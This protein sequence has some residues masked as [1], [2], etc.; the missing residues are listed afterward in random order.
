LTSVGFFVSYWALKNPDNSKLMNWKPLIMSRASTLLASCLLAGG[1]IS[2][3]AVNW[4]GGSLDS[5][6]WSDT[7]NWDSLLAPGS[8]DVVT[9]TSAGSKQEAGV[10]DNVVDSD[11]TVAS[12][13][14][15]AP[16]SAITPATNYHTTLIN[17]G[18]TLTLD[19]GEVGAGLLS[20]GQT[21]DSANQDGQFYYTITGSGGSLIAGNLESPKTNQG[22]QVTATQR[23]FTNHVGSLDLSGLD[24]FSMAGGYFWVGI[25]GDNT[26]A[27]DR[28]AGRVYLAKTNRI[29]MVGTAYDDLN[30]GSFRVGESRGNT[31][32]QP[33]LVELG[34]DNSIFTP[35]LKIGG[36]RTGTATNSGG[37]MYFRSGLTNPTLKL[38]WHQPARHDAN[39][40]QLMVNHRKLDWFAWH[41]RS[42][43]RNSRCA[44]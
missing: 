7:N 32:N 12:I 26:V 4:T 22:F 25:N 5:L 42:E 2:A 37:F 27:T 35:W 44:G 13:N 38:R 28:P 1:V 23:S 6:L 19:R 10:V 14:Y 9:F 30:F 11:T 15:I 17:P 39:Q 43:W 18:V 8:T 20:V 31:P 29:T 36:A 40:R 21:S 34:Q 16:V 41:R 3:H 33:S 24:N